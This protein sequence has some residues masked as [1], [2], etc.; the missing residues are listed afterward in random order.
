MKLA[1][2]AFGRLRS[3]AL[4]ELATD[5]AKRIGRYVKLETVELREERGDSPAA[6]RK[7]AERLAAALR[8]DD[9]WVLLDERGPQFSSAEL[10]GWLRDRERAG[11]GSR[12][13]FLVG[14]PFGVDAAVR[15]RARLTLSPSRLTLPHELARVVLLEQLYRAYTILRGEPYHHA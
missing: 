14:G 4:R 2:L 13:V 3:A 10:A 7:E 9:F 1:V 6:R 15:A 5:Y 11:G 8:D 12:T